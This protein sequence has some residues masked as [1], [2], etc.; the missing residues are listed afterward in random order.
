M[1]IG[2]FQKALLVL[3][4]FASVMANANE[5]IGSQA[6]E[7][8]A[9]QLDQKSL[10][11]LKEKCANT[12]MLTIPNRSECTREVD[13]AVLTQ[14][15]FDYCQGKERLSDFISCI[16]NLSGRDYPHSYVEA[17]KKVRDSNLTSIK[18]C[19]EYLAQ[20]E[21]SFDSEAFHFCLASN[22]GKFH[23]AKPCINAI[24]DRKV[25]AQ[26]LKR[27]CIDERAMGESFN[28]CVFRLTDKAP[29]V[30]SCVKK[31][32]PSSSSAVSRSGTR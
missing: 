19:H 32:S 11:I 25:D 23:Y 8:K 24:R 16:E 26:K 1:K 12:G 4:S 27:E 14:E 7:I 13:A 3:I 29:S 22:E 2:S 5:L 30:A 10:A 21:S 15:S 28:D 17:C 31:A 18:M 20:T 9:H 6:P